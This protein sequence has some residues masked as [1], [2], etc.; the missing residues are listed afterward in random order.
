MCCYSCNS[1]RSWRGA[2]QRPSMHDCAWGACAQAEAPLKRRKIA[3]FTVIQRFCSLLH[4]YHLTAK[5][6]RTFTVPPP[7]DT[8]T[9]SHPTPDTQHAHTP[10]NALRLIGRAP[11]HTLS[12][13]LPDALAPQWEQNATGARSMSCTD[14][15]GDGPCVVPPP[16]PCIANVKLWMSPADCCWENSRHPS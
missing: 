2:A 13:N 14:G 16:R 9:Q 4:F 1:T 3:T 11:D 15:P 12:K 8:H 5:P 7:Y 6:P 10:H